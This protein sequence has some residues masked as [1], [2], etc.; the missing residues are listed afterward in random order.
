MIDEI[1]MAKLEQKYNTALAWYNEGTLTA[2]E[3]V[4]ICE[5]VLDEMM[6]INSDLLQRLKG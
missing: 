3:F 2:A 6:K 1:R 4:K 5:I